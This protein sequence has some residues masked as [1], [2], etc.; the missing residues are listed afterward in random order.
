MPEHLEKKARD[1]LKNKK[2]ETQRII[3]KQTIERLV[4]PLNRNS[5]T[6]DRTG[7]DRNERRGI[8]NLLDRTE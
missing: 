1:I 7:Y 3:E 8:E 6:K 4:K 5:I 2:T